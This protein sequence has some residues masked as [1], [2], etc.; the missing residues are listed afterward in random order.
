MLDVLSTA[1]LYMGSKSVYSYIHN[2]IRSMHVFFFHLFIWII[3][4]LARDA[5]VALFENF[6]CM[7]VCTLL[8]FTAI[9]SKLC[10]IPDQFMRFLH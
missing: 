4:T 10:P 1:Y 9:Y 5:H 2:H 3:V 7:C 6:G 8:Q